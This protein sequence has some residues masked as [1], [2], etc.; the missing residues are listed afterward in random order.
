MEMQGIEPL[1]RPA[2]A[3][4]DSALLTLLCAVIIVN[5]LCAP[6]LVRIA[7]NFF[8]QLFRSHRG[9]MAGEKTLGERLVVS[10]GTVQAMLFLALTLYCACGAT[11]IPPIAAVCGLLVLVCA[12]YLFQAA[13]YLLVGYAFSTPDNTRLWLSAFQITQAAGSFML[14]IPAMAALFYPAFMVPFVAIVGV[15][16]I[17]TRI[18]LYIK[19]FSFFYTSPASI[20]Y[21]FLYLCALEIVPLIAVWSLAD[22]FSSLFC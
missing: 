20:V 14:I 1:M 19:E 21:F 18:P 5:L 7:G 17:A 2:L 22:V 13:G 12:L 9:A 10:A 15:I 3:A 11:Q 6:N 8:K 4:T 16:Y